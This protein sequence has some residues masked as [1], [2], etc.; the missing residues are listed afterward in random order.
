MAKVFASALGMNDKD[1]STIG[2]DQTHTYTWEDRRHNIEELFGIE[3]R[4]T[5]VGRHWELYFNASRYLK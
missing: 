2:H 3:V 1:S 5:R 4:F